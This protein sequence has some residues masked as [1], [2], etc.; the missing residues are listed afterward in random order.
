VIVLLV[1]FQIWFSLQ[2]LSQ[3]GRALGRLESLEST[4]AELRASLTSAGAVEPAA[5]GAGLGDAGLDVGSDAPGFSLPGVDGRTHTLDSLVDESGRLM[6]VFSDADCGPCNA[7][8]PELAEW[9]RTHRDRLGVVVIATGEPERNRAKASED[10]LDRVLLAESRD[11]ADA[12]QARLT[13]AAVVVG[14]DGL[15]ESPVVAG[16]DAIRALVAQTDSHPAPLRRP[17]APASDDR[18]GQPVPALELPGLDG[19]PVELA[20]MY[21]DRTLTIFWNPECGFCQQ[22]L[23]DLKALERDPPAGA[24]RLLVISSGSAER[25]RADG[26]RSRVVLDPRSE[27]IEAFTASGTPMGVL[28]EDGRIASPVAAGAAAVL[29]LAGA[30]GGMPEVVH[31]GGGGR[32]S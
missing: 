11:V 10:G 6:F 28:V 5:L 12:F 4:V 14:A 7:L 26:L 21:R 31:A 30:V 23:P 16:A 15:V 18:I 22:M 17:R 2:L 24:P 29:Q 8:L 13:P 9:Q 3:N 27:A 25:V 20:D 1:A 32:A 19:R